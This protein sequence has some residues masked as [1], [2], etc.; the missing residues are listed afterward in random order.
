[1]RLRPTAVIVVA[2][3]GILGVVPAAAAPTQPRETLRGTVDDSARIFLRHA[4]GRSVT[5]LEP[6]QY[7][8]VVEDSSV[9]HNFHLFGAGV[10]QTTSVENRETVTWTVNFADAQTYRFQCDPH[11]DT[12]RGSF[13]VGSVPPPPP[14]PP[15]PVRRLT[16]S[17]T[18][19]AISVRTASGSKARTV[20]RG[21]YRIAVRD[22]SRTQNFHLIGPGLNRKTTVGG[23][24]KPTWTVTLRAGTYIYRSDRN[25]RLRG[26]FRAR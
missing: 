19:R 8:I 25:R 24:A 22:T 2:L 12:M 17:V 20:A 18:S 9:D 11:A 10:N 5:H 7:A 15:A 26:S 4:D 13:T 21:R 14:P 6:G 16:A 23:T 1:M 3:A